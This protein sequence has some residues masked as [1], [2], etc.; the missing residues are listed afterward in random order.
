MIDFSHDSSKL[1][2]KALYDSTRVANIG[3]K[4]SLTCELLPRPTHYCSLPTTHLLISNRCSCR[5]YQWKTVTHPSIIGRFEAICVRLIPLEL[6]LNA[7]A[8]PGTRCVTENNGLCSRWPNSALPVPP[9]ANGENRIVDESVGT[10]WISNNWANFNI[11]F[12]RAFVLPFVSRCFAAMHRMW[13][14]KM[15]L[16]DRMG[17]RLAEPPPRWIVKWRQ[18]ESSLSPTTSTSCK[19]PTSFATPQPSRFES[20]STRINC[21]TSMTK[22]RRNLVLSFIITVQAIKSLL[23]REREKKIIDL[24]KSHWKLIKCTASFNH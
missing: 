11:F 21:S 23:S 20:G 13:S 3:I 7:D 22:N 1:W 2:T 8:T 5:E 19:S 6:G 12:C 15:N 4:Q 9:A 10:S 17:L 16:A 18:R 14:S 24:P